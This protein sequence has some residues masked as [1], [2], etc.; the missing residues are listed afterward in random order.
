MS[1]TTKCKL[2]GKK[3][4]GTTQAQIDF[5]LMVHTNAKHKERK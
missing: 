5:Y 1:L 4:E 3:F 2:C